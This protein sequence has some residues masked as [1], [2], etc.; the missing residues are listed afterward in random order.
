MQKPL[1]AGWPKEMR[2]RKKS[3][4]LM[5]GNDTR[6]GQLVKKLIS[7]NRQIKVKQQKIVSRAEV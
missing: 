4:G 3:M 2:K 1:E 7:L 5:A 6:M